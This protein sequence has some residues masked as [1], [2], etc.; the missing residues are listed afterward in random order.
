MILLGTLK[1]FAVTESYQ[2]DPNIEC[3]DSIVTIP[4]KRI[5]RFDPTFTSTI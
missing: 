1:P 5:E 3:D 4:S 2:K